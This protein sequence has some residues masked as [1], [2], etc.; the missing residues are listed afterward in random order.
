MQLE[1][2]KL[3]E[4]FFKERGLGRRQLAER[5]GYRNLNRGMRHVTAWLRGEA[6]PCAAHI[7]LLAPA[8]EMPRAELE[9][10]VRRDAVA[11]AEEARRRRALDPRFYLIIRYMPAVYGSEVLGED[12]DEQEALAA[13]A[14][15]AARIQRRCCLST[16]SSRCYWLSATGAL[17]GVNRGPEPTMQV[18]GRPF[19]LLV[20]G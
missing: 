1:L 19:R 16:P 3:I 9:A 17:E 12:L 10:L 8:L 5:M 18:G 13:A 11:L 4:G 14:A 15:R 2:P 7:D 6:L 20:D